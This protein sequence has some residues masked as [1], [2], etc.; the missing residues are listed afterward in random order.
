MPKVLTA[1]RLRDIYRYLDGKNVVIC[2]EMETDVLDFVSNLCIH[3]T[4]A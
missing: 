2:R 1:N 4:E 3:I